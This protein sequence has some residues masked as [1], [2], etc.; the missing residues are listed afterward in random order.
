MAC[1]YSGINHYLGEVILSRGGNIIE[2]V[3]KVNTMV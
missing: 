3:C 1:M 2:F